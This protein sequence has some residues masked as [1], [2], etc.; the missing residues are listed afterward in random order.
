MNSNASTT[1]DQQQQQPKK[2]HDRHKDKKLKR[3]F[4]R[5]KKQLEEANRVMHSLDKHKNKRKKLRHGNNDHH[6]HTDNNNPSDS[7]A[8]TTVTTAPRYQVVQKLGPRVQMFSENAS[9][10]H[11]DSN[12][13]NN[14]GNNSRRS[15]MI[16][17]T[18]YKAPAKSL[19][20]RRSALAEQR[21]NEEVEQSESAV[22]DDMDQLHELSNNN[23]SNNINQC[24][25]C[26]RHFAKQLPH[27][28]G[29]F[30]SQYM[31][32]FPNYR[33]ERGSVCAA[34]YETC[35]EF[36]SGNTDVVTCAT[37]STSIVG[38][39]YKLEAHLL[40]YKRCFP[41]LNIT[42]GKVCSKCF[43]VCRKAR[44]QEEERKKRIMDIAAKNKSGGGGGAGSKLSLSSMKSNSSSGG[45]GGSTVEAPKKTKL[46]FSAIR[47]DNKGGDEVNKSIGKANEA[48]GDDDDDDEH[49]SQ[50]VSAFFEVD[51]EPSKKVFKLSVDRKPSVDSLLELVQQYLD[52]AY[53]SLK[54][55]ATSLK[56]IEKDGNDIEVA[57]DVIPRF[58]ER[59][60][61]QPKSKFIVQV[62]Q[63]QGKSKKRQKRK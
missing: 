44:V 6:D 33:G 2:K 14:N 46:V 35:R 4:E 48:K 17:V 10:A 5:A 52:N 56:L 9:P 22:I 34:C 26:K 7:S 27:K 49:L 47:R 19:T 21:A 55:R 39:S 62:E 43:S 30:R 24:V 12:N 3:Q 53:S 60:P 11:P 20:K 63:D 1:S 25:V 37:C 59:Y 18:N 16:I 32:C 51:I 50:S 15:S 28:S 38:V 42:T 8:T 36:R 40:E 54:L 41:Q 61:I 57:I 58:F 13:N 45:D 29:M 23:D 31:S